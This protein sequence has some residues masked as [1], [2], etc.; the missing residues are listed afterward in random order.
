MRGEIDRT[1][2]RELRDLYFEPKGEWATNRVERVMKAASLTP[3]DR[4]LDLGCNLGTFSHHAKLAG[5]SPIGLDWNY[6]AL[7]EG[8][9]V[10]ACI[11]GFVLPRVQ[12]DGRQLPFDGEVFDVIINADFIEHTADD[13]K[14]PIFSEMYRVLRKGGRAVV[15]TPNLN[16][17]RWELFGE[18]VKRWLGLRSEMVPS[19]QDFVDPD[20]FGLTTPWETAAKLKRAGF[21]T[22]T[23]YFQFHVPLISKIPGTNRLMVP[24]LSAQFGDRFLI[25]ARQ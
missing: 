10:S 6:A 22:T 23:N 2:I 7:V 20:H 17:I 4:V 3:N 21:T 8:R 5:A 12:A 15:Y 25:L 16:K 14:P 19:W 11:G 13:A 18:R 9:E 1:R 24:C